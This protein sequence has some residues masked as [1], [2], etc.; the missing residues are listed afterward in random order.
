[1]GSVLQHRSP[2][3]PHPTSRGL[4]GSP[5][6]VRVALPTPRRPLLA[7]QH[8]LRS[9]EGAPHGPR[10]CTVIPRV[11][12]RSP[13]SDDPKALWSPRDIS[14]YA[15]HS[16][17]LHRDVKVTPW[18]SQDAPNSSSIS[19]ISPMALRLSQRAPNG[20]SAPSNILLVNPRWTIQRFHRPTYLLQ[21]FG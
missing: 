18:P 6:G 21:L 15:P 16:P 2:P 14:G 8:R 4:F 10:R 12:L 11:V 1:M 3:A 7:P 5:Q 13:H 19:Q 17:Q 9:L 20:S